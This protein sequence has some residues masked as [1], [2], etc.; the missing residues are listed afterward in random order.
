MSSDWKQAQEALRNA[1]EALKRKD[2]RAARRWAEQAASLAPDQ[3]EPWLFLAACAS[4]R[5]S[6]AYLERAL[7][8]NPQSDYARRGM[9]WAIDR[10][11][12]DPTHPKP[13]RQII[14][15]NITPEALTRSR[16]ALLPWALILIMAVVG[17]FAWFSTPTFSFAFGGREAMPIAQVDVDKATTGAASPCSDATRCLR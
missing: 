1:Q 3:E 4:P 5:A 16:P 6:L 11:R 13:P 14:S 10:W 8:I 7:E 17:F 9:H 2:H 12:H 15:T